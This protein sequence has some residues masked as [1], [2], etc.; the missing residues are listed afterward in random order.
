[1]SQCWLFRLAL[2]I[3]P[4]IRGFRFSVAMNETGSTTSNLG[5]AKAAPLLA[6]S[7]KLIPLA[8]FIAAF[9]VYY[10]SNSHSGSYYDYTFRIAE[11]MLD[12]R[13]GLTERPPDWLNEMV[14]LDGQYYS[15]FPLGA[16]LAMLPPAALKRLGLIELFPGTLIAALLAGA[17]SLLFYLLSSRYGDGVK[18]R[19]M[20]TL[21]PVFGTWMW[22]NLAFAG[23][24]QIALGIAVVGQ[25]GAL[26]FILIDHRRTLLRSGLRQSYG[27]HS[28]GADFH[29][30]DHQTRAAGRRKRRRP[31]AA[32]DR[33]FRSDPDRP[34][35]FDARLQLRAV[36]FRLRFR[37]REDSGRAR[38]AVVP[39][40]HLL[41]SCHPAQRRGDAVRNL[42][43]RRPLPL[44]QADRIR[45]INLSE[46]P[47]LG[48]PVQNRRA[49]RHVEDAGVGRHRGLDAH[50][51][52]TRQPRRMANLLPLRDGAAAVD[53]SDP[54]RKLPE[55]GRPDRSG[56][57]PR[58]DS[59]QRILD[60]AV[61][62]D[63]IYQRLS[64]GRH[65]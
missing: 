53:V 8:L 57:A 35:P 3:V 43:A 11:A 7:T 63:A 1:M 32:D 15:V 55:E 64:T 10:F 34:R 12:G 18:R 52:A 47:F 33:P 42:A 2:T 36:L 41:D 20:L 56:A 49:R 17:A 30:P 6:R 50:P 37:L 28:A 59:D 22:A 60:V 65:N 14:P 31:P 27:D 44:P 45:R 38:R 16:V 25:L 26:Y 24:W 21:L 54:A 39:A 58:L 5:S 23:A 4:A 40:R 29:L 61:F 62:V 46:L 13:L 9:A 19:L 48:L 51:L